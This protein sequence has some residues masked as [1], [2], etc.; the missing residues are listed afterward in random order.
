DAML[1]GA[2]WLTRGKHQKRIRRAT[3]VGQTGDKLSLHYDAELLRRVPPTP[4]LLADEKRYSIWLKPAGLL[5]QGTMEGDHCSLLRLCEQQLQREVYL[6]HRLDRE[7]AGLMLIAH[8]GKSAA[9][10]SQLF[11]AAKTELL[12]K[13]YVVLAA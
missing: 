6:V 2:V 7:A 1:K 10:F 9:A 5:A 4:Q 8:D 13:Q 12:Q 11:A 3:F